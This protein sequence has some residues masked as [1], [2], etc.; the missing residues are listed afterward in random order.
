MDAGFG[1]WDAPRQATFRV[2]YYAEDRRPFAVHA[3]SADVYYSTAVQ[4]A[5]EPADWVLLESTQD[6]TDCL[7][8]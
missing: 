3:L 6:R 2:D 1:R 7:G 8:D 4:R 5:P